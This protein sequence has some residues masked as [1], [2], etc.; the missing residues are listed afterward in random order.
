LT[1]ND[2]LFTN[3]WQLFPLF[4]LKEKVFHICP[5]P[6]RTARRK[7]NSGVLGDAALLP[8]FL[9]HICELQIHGGR[10]VFFFF[11]PNLSLLK[12]QRNFAYINET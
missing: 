3:R 5:L 7:Q 4:N 9:R 11:S 1:N 8:S 2:I 6:H 10:I 12:E